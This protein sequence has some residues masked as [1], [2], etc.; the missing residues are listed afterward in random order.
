MSKHNPFSS[1]LS[2]NIV[3]AIL[4]YS[5]SEFT[6]K[7]EKTRK[8][9]AKMIQV[10]VLD[11]TYI[12]NKSY[13]NPKIIAPLLKSTPFEAHLMVS[14]PEKHIERWAKLRPK[15]IIF[16]IDSTNNPLKTVE[17]IKKAKITPVVAIN[18]NTKIDALGLIFREIS[19]ILVMGVN[20]GYGGQRFRP[21][22]LKKIKTIKQKFP[23]LLIEVD[24]G[25]RATNAQ[26]I[27]DAG[28]DT[29]AVGSALFETVV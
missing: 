16:H 18:P 23:G 4:A 2:P 28:A 5:R 17:A 14:N 24:G 9:K 11:G 19:A 3:P 8:I 26:K 10:D 13:S 21:S 7:L 20:P 27:L 15:R 6:E 25:V 1:P 29:L 22:T 12:D